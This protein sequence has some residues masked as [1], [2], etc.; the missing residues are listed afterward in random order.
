MYDRPIIH[1][2]GWYVWRIFD[3]SYLSCLRNTVS[4][5]KRCRRHSTAPTNLAPESM[6]IRAHLAKAS[7][8][9]HAF[10][11]SIETWD[12]SPVMCCL[13]QTRWSVWDNTLSNVFQILFQVSPQPPLPPFVSISPLTSNCATVTVF[14]DVTP[15]SLVGRYQ[16]NGAACCLQCSAMRSNSFT[17]NRKL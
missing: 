14:C 5:E 17:P 12:E 16:S 7:L 11:S 15:C 8:P 1:N 6:K 2:K 10:V 9:R 3:L 13:I 4:V